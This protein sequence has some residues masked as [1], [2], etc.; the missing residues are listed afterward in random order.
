RVVAKDVLNAAGTRLL[1]RTEYRIEP[2][3]A[4]LGN[5]WF[6]GPVH[7]IYPPLNEIQATHRTPV[8]RTRIARY[9]DPG[10][11]VASNADLFITETTEFH[12]C[13]PPR[14]QIDARPDGVHRT[15]HRSWQHLLAQTGQ[16]GPWRKIGLPA[17]LSVDAVPL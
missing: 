4:K 8:T 6:P 13:G 10:S 16:A 9:P 15:L 2:I 17:T 3:G 5:H 12:A 14:T 1:E 7:G 11:P